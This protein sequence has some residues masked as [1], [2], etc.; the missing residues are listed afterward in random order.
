MVGCRGCRTGR[1]SEASRM[2]DGPHAGQS[3][4]GLGLWTLLNQGAFW[5]TYEAHKRRCEHSMLCEIWGSPRPVSQWNVPPF[6]MLRIAGGYEP[7]GCSAIWEFRCFWSRPTRP[8]PPITKPASGT[9][10]P[11]TPNPPEPC[12][13]IYRLERHLSFLRNWG[14]SRMWENSARKWSDF[15]FE[16]QENRFLPKDF[17]DSS[18]HIWLHYS[19][20]FFPARNWPMTVIRQAVII[21]GEVFPRM[22]GQEDHARVHFNFYGYA[23]GRKTWLRMWLHTWLLFSAN[24]QITLIANSLEWS[25]PLGPDEWELPLRG[26]RCLALA[27]ILS[28]LATGHKE[29]VITRQDNYSNAPHSLLHL[30]LL[31]TPLHTLITPIIHPPF[32]PKTSSSQ[33]LHLRKGRIS[34]QPSSERQIFPARHYIRWLQ[35]IHICAEE[36]QWRGP[37]GPPLPPSPDLAHGVGES[38]FTAVSDIC[39]FSAPM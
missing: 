10:A 21:S 13:H 28:R 36:M 14:S 7:C 6:I 37:V 18:R 9:T 4:R 5:S 27:S 20:S 1:A 35:Q 11:T 32:L 8:P 22:V 30:H 17:R 19:T 33:H 39:V 31:T 3:V 12:R 15:D 2:S 23:R 25:L 24:Q 16:F 26:A 38:V 29:R 34:R